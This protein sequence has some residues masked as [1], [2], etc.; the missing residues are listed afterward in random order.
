MRIT[1]IL[2]VS[3]IIMGVVSC[4]KGMK[5]KTSLESEVDSASYALGL[6]MSSQLKRNF[7]DVN[8]DL[9]IQGFQ[10]GLDSSNLLIPQKDAISV[11]NAFFQKK[12]KAKREKQQAEQLAKAEKDFADWKKENED[13]LEVNKSKSGVNT[14][15]SGLQYIIVKEGKG[16]V[17]KPTDR[18]KIHYRGKNIKGEEF[19]SS[20]KAKKP[21]E[22]FP[23]Q[24]VPGFAEGLQLM[25]KG[26]KY[27][28]FIPQDLAYKFQQRGKL[29]KP[30]STLVFD[31]EMIDVTSKK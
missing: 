20:Y 13:F 12:Q 26:A 1:K 18:I 17:V 9:F 16:D 8:K 23:T 28:F 19:D 27:K 29:I 22:A 4:N 5:T 10:N 21:Y 7:E 31:V 11:L 30:F 6:N 15:K 3:V 24:F 25:K 14:T 2:A